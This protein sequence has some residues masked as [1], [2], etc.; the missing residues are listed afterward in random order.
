M[1][2]AADD[3]GVSGLS[4]IIFLLFP[5]KIKA[6]TFFHEIFFTYK[7]SAA[8][9]I[10][11]YVTKV[12]PLYFLFPAFLLDPYKRED[13]IKRP[14][15]LKPIMVDGMEYRRT[16]LGI[17][18]GLLRVWLRN[19]QKIH[20]YSRNPTLHHIQLHPRNTTTTIIII[21]IFQLKW[22]DVVRVC[23]QCHV[24]VHRF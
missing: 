12:W 9:Y 1:V 4:C 23:L 21:I 24:V 2:V 18:P 7:S 10:H 13:R 16:L 22:C 8:E 3:D 5:I 20:I 11:T 19:T 17:R 14:R 6:D 15:N